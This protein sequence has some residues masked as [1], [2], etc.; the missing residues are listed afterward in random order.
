MMRDCRLRRIRKKNF[1]EGMQGE[2]TA[3]GGVGGEAVFSMIDWV[4]LTCAQHG[5]GGCAGGGHPCNQMLRRSGYCCPERPLPADPSARAVLV[6][7]AKAVEPDDAMGA[8]RPQKTGE[9]ATAGMAGSVPFYFLCTDSP[10]ADASTCKAPQ[11]AVKKR[12]ASP[13]A[14]DAISRSE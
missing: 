7:V 13:Y 11:G 4:G 3:E 8:S 14:E 1:H 10:L 9:S 2:R 5:G 6:G 12:D